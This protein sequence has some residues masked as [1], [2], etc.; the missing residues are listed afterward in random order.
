MKLLDTDTCIGLLKGD[1]AVVASWRACM[2]Q[3]ALPSMVVGEL[4]YGAFKSTIRDKELERVHRFVDIFP[5][6]K[7]SKRSMRRFG[8]IKA[9][10]ERKGVRLADADIIIGSIA[11]EEGLVLVTGNVRHYN[12]IEGLAIENWFL[13]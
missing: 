3:C 10:L 13:R 5:E 9:S 1:D 11:I 7:P 2:E 8:E 4:Y 12:R 6:V